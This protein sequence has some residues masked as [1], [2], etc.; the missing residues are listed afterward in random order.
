M[1]RRGEWVVRTAPAAMREELLVRVRTREEREL[2]YPEELG[3][4]VEHEI[5]V[6]LR[7]FGEREAEAAERRPPAL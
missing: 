7:G 1:H 2:R 3:R 5:A 6:L 4:T